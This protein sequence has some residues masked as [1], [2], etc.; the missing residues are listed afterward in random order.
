MLSLK[1]NMY[2]TDSF[3]T[4]DIF[5]LLENYVKTNKIWFSYFKFIDDEIVSIF[6]K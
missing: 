5:Y 2:K 6:K 3:Q 4:E 1:N